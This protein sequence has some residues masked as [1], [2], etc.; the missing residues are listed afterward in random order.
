MATYGHAH[1]MVVTQMHWARSAVRPV[2]SP[3]QA[4][5]WPIASLFNDPSGE[6]ETKGAYLTPR[7][8]H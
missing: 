6:W 2:E 8:A 1:N 3:K 4:T 7:R 5:Y